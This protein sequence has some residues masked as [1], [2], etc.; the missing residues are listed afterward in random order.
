MNSESEKYTNLGYFHL[1]R[2]LGM[3]LIL[4]GHSISPFFPPQEAAQA[5]ELFSGAGSVL[6]GGIM[7]MFFM[8]SG[9]GFYCRSPRKTLATQTKLLLKPYWITAAAILLT[10]LLLALVKQR[11]FARHGAV[12]VLTYLLGLNAEGGGTL[13]GIPIESVSIFW[14]ILALFG[15]WMICNGIYRIKSG[16]M[17]LLLTLGSVLLSFCLC[18]ISR[19]W[20]FCLPMMLLSAGYLAA[21]YEMKCHQLL[22]RRLPVWFW[23]IIA[24]VTLISMAF[25]RINI[26][27]CHWGLGLQDVA[28]TFSTGFLLMQL[29]HRISGFGGN[30]PIRLLLEA[31]GYHSL[32]IVF[33]HGYEKVIFPWHRLQYIFP[34]SP[35]L[36]VAV[37]FLGRCLI[38]GLLI[39]LI[40]TVKRKLRRKRSRRTII[41]EP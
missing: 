7:A 20:P 17:R 21:G 11:P 15:G 38:I 2:G 13:A 14:F 40:S 9:F 37:C 36:C 28:A 22:D 24:A 35:A 16:M 29:Y 23:C 10:K 30:N 8:I 6:G 41:I 12:Y 5:Q 3:V 31:V 4:L 39:R 32:W 18:L 26:V 34:D 1:A 33:L 19:I 25:G 27:A